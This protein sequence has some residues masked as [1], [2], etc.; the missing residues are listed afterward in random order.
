MAEKKTFPL[1]LRKIHLGIAWT[2]K[3]PENLQQ[4]YNYAMLLTEALNF[5][6]VILKEN[7]L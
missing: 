2:R 4:G 3:Q 6:Q 1:E 5:A 7:I